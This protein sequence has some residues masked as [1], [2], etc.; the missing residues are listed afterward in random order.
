[1]PVVDANRYNHG[2]TSV[3]DA[4][5]KAT[6]EM[7]NNGLIEA[8]NGRLRAACLNENW[9]LSLDDAMATIAAWR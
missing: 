2:Q 3:A 8:F 6:W 7:S 4:R 5:A 1:M 9:F